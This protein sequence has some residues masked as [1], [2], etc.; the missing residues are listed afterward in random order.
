MTLQRRRLFLAVLGLCL[1]VPGTALGKTA[2]G[3]AP[4]KASTK[5][6]ILI[7]IVGDQT[8]SSDLGR[9]YG[10]LDQ[11]V[12]VP[13]GGSA[14][15]AGTILAFDVRTSFTGAAGKL[16]VETTVQTTVKACP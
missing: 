9:A 8:L 13:A 3:K 5:R 15:A 12:G 4:A 2:P 16:F 1:A 11:G 14:P 6:P 10:I 7:G